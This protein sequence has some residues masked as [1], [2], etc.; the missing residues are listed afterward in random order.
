M[1]DG[2]ESII[3]DCK[4][5][6]IIHI[7]PWLAIPDVQGAAQET[8]KML[9]LCHQQNPKLYYEVGTE[10]RIRYMTIEHIDNF[11]NILKQDLESEIY[12]RIVFLVIQCGTKLYENTNVGEYDEERLS[13]MLEVCQKYDKIPKEHNGDYVSLDILQTKIAKGVNTI[14]IAPEFGQIETKVILEELPSR[15]FE[16]FYQI[17]YLSGK[18]KKWV[19]EGFDPAQNKEKLIEIC[20]HYVFAYPEFIS[21][22]KQSGISKSKITDKLYAKMS[23][24][25][26]LY[27]PQEGSK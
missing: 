3:E 12:E 13:K 2:V 25:Y 19:S 17:C 23:Q 27:S 22:I 10:E 20:G 1:D 14:N 21:L 15:Y 8:I 16:E 4:Y 26:Q 7:D 18:W 24:L 11:M 9:R 5:F 6:D